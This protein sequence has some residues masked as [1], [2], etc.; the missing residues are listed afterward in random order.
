MGLGIST[1]T[2]MRQELKANPRLYQ[3]MKLLYMPL[4][5]LQAH[6]NE[7][8]LS[9]PFLDMAEPGDE[10]PN[11]ESGN[12]DQSDGDQVDW[13][14]ILLDGFDVGGRPAEYEEKEYFT[15]TPA[16]TRDL[17]DHLRDQLSLIKLEP[18]EVLIG[19][20]IIGNIDREGFLSCTLAQIFEAVNNY[21]SNPANPWAVASEDDEDPIDLSAITMAEVEGMLGVIQSLEP[22]GIGARDLRETLLL[23][24]RDRGEEDTLAFQIVR[25]RFD[26]FVNHRWNDLAKEHGITPQEVQSAADEVAKLDPKRGL[27]YS[28]SSDSYVIPDLTVEKV[29]GEYSVFHNDTTITRLKLSQSYREVAAQ[30]GQF[31]GANKAFISE[32]LNGALWMIQAVEQR[33]QTMLKVMKFIVHRQRDFFEKG[34][35]HLRPLA[36]R[37]VADHIEM[38]ES[39]VSRFANEKY[40]QTPRGLFPLK[41]FFSGGLSTDYGEDV[42]NRGVR[43]RIE[44]IVAKEDSKAPFTDPQ[45]LDLLRKEGVQIARRT[46]AKYRDELGILSARLRKRL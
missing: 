38:H 31:E 20:E 23:Q 33:R 45:I 4:L 27:K 46:V 10:S 7:E 2:H 37:E 9:N 18:R 30:R 32:K 6:L 41:F 17:W 21:L 29:D 14:E 5:D 34:V 35:E 16:A 13:E 43:A 3:A 39:T 15:P 11:D 24:L 8:L 19:E 25:D 44:K 12:Q 36:Q 40:V 1:G 26:D 22:S 28:D 42:S